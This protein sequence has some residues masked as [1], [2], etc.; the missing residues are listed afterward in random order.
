[1]GAGPTVHDEEYIAIGAQRA[2]FPGRPDRVDPVRRELPFPCGQQR[3]DLPDR[4]PDRLGREPPDDRAHMW[5]IPERAERTA[6]EVEAVERHL[7]WRVRDRE[8]ADQRPEQRGL[9][10]LRR[11]DDRDVPG[12]AVQRQP[13]RIPPL[14]VRLVDDRR[15]GP[16][17]GRARTRRP[18]SGHDPRR[19]RAGRAPHPADPTWSAAAARPD[20]PARPDRRS[21]RRSLRASSARVRPAR[22][23]R[24]PV[25]RPARCR[26]A[27]VPMGSAARAT[28]IPQASRAT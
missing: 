10:G 18:W 20:G 27:G 25:R 2:R 7:P 24:S 15:P 22:W 3:G 23:T 13:Q 16:A 28:P 1:M 21:H 26:T 14:L 9:A 11:A 19:G 6:A 8:P 12:G 17:A 4:T 5:Q